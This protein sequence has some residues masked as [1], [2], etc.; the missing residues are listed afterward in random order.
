MKY[1]A[2]SVV[3]MAEERQL[4]NYSNSGQLSTV[5]NK[6]ELRISSVSMGFR[7]RFAAH[8]KSMLPEN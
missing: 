3:E 4:S 6:T 5:L 1:M 7:D 8:F 2:L